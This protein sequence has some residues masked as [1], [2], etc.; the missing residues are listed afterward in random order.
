MMD[1][2]PSRWNPLYVPPT[3]VR[4]SICKMMDANPSR[5]NLTDVSRLNWKLIR[6]PGESLPP[7]PPCGGVSR[8]GPGKLVNRFEDSKNACTSSTWT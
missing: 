2:N 3:G 5:W 7:D 8:G 6:T 1:A 4:T